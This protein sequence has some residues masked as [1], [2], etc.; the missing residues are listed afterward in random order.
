MKKNKNTIFLEVL[1]YS[2]KILKLIYIL[3]IIS[4]VVV[5]VMFLNNCGIL[6]ILKKILIVLVPFFIGFIVAFLT[7]PIIN[8]LHK[9]GLPKILVALLIYAV[10]FVG[11]YFLI[12]YILPS[13]YI[14]MNKLFAILPDYIKNIKDYL[15]AMINNDAISIK[16]SDS[17]SN[18]SNHLISNFPEIVFNFI[19]SFIGGIGVFLFGLVIG[20][21]MI[22][23][24]DDIC[25]YF[26]RLIPRKYQMEYQKLITNIGFEVRKTVN[27]TLIVASFVFVFSSF[28]FLALGIDN[29]F[30]YGLIC[31]I[32]DLIPYIGPYIG[33]IPAVLVGFSISKNI[34]ILT[35]VLLVITQSLENYI[36]Q[37]IVM[38][39]QTKLNPLVIILGLLLFGEL[40]GIIGLLVATPILTLLKVIIIFIKTKYQMKHYQ[41]V[42][43]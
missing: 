4:V 1:L 42:K 3:L 24:Y 20:L 14:Q 23:N 6:L 11:L 17:I 29:P 7:F 37:P 2:R 34:G 19:K 12:K 15:T 31:G 39:K 22:L 43:D 33:G 25:S 5:F 26:M 21:Y 8:F 30:V 36:L 35:I 28:G 32:T 9:Y 16:I 27:G 38:S 41:L 40:F 10:I 18:Y 13:L